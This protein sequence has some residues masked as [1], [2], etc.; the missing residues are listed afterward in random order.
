MGKG[1][2]VSQSSPASNRLLISRRISKIFR[3]LAKD[4]KVINT[5]KEPQPTYESNHNSNENDIKPKSVGCEEEIPSE[6]SDLKYSCEEYSSPSIHTSPRSVSSSSPVSVLSNR[7]RISPTTTQA[8]QHPLAKSSNESISPRKIKPSPKQI[9]NSMKLKSKHRAEQFSNEFS[10]QQEDLNSVSLSDKVIESKENEYEAMGQLEPW[11]IAT[12]LSFLRRKNQLYDINDEDIPVSSNLIIKIHAEYLLNALKQSTVQLSRRDLEIQRLA[13]INKRLGEQYIMDKERILIENKQ[14]EAELSETRQMLMTIQERDNQ[15]I[16]HIGRVEADIKENTLN[17]HNADGIIANL[18]AELERKQAK[19]D[20]LTVKQHKD[21][22]REIKTRIILNE[23]IELKGN[24]RV[25]IRC[26]SRSN[27]ESAFTSVEDDTLILK[28]ISMIYPLQECAKRPIIHFFKVHRLFPPNTPQKSIYTEVSELITSCV[29]GY[30]VAIVTYG[31]NGTGKTYTILGAQGK[32]GIIPRAARQLFTECQQRQPAWTYRLSI[33]VVQIYKENIIDLLAEPEQP[34]KKHHL[35][36]ITIHDNGEQIILHGATEK[37]VSSEEEILEVIH[38]ARLRRYASSKVLQASLSNLHFIIIIRVRG[39][40]LLANHASE[41]HQSTPRHVVSSTNMSANT[42][43]IPLQYLNTP[44]SPAYDALQLNKNAKGRQENR[45]LLFA[46]HGLLMFADLAVD[47][48]TSN[49]KSHAV[50]CM[51]TSLVVLNR[52]MTSLSEREAAS[53]KHVHIPFRDSKLTHILKPALSGDA[54]FLLI[55]T[56]DIQ[57]S[58]LNTSLKSLQLA[59]TASSI[60]LGKAKQNIADKKGIY[61]S[62]YPYASRV[63]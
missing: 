47:N 19:I 53:R 8:F 62:L 6:D 57:K 24:I 55:I 27:E 49:D 56:L 23:L 31:Q 32:P 50:K 59:T 52:V 18:K 17:K 28:P 41:I 12:D 9:K 16:R 58:H 43:G 40:C 45:N 26:I 48:N 36:K 33:A 39:A 35:K 29:D 46:T 3:K 61:T 15:I 38:K 30:T 20:A 1:E 54:K 21:A 44:S 10:D 42:T 14:L 11:P 25:I 34:T 4:I 60:C 37:E 5:D 2:L 51:D 63:D 22:A 7:M 13:A